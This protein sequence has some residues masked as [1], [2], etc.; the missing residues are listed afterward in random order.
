MMAILR[1]LAE[2]VAGDEMIDVEALTFDGSGGLD[3]IGDY[4]GAVGSVVALQAD[5]TSNIKLGTVN[6]NGTF[7]TNTTNYTGINAIMVSTTK[8]VDI[9]NANQAYPIIQVIK[10]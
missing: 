7:T 4:T 6:S 2:G 9:D 10:Q 5:Q 3:I 1:W 8:V